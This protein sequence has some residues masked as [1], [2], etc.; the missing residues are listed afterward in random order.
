[1]SQVDE[2]SEND[3]VFPGL[4]RSRHPLAGGCRCLQVATRVYWLGKFLSAQSKIAF[5]LSGTA[6]MM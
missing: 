6:M 5:F 4:F 1:M 2:K 3:A